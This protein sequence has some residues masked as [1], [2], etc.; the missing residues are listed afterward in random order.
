MPRK[1]KGTE[2]NQEQILE[3]QALFEGSDYGSVKIAEII[4]ERHKIAITEGSVRHYAKKGGWVKGKKKEYYNAKKLAKVEETLAKAKS[5]EKEYKLITKIS[6]QAEKEGERVA[7][8]TMQ[9]ETFKQQIEHQYAK[10]M[11]SLLQNFN[12]TQELTKSGKVTDTEFEYLGK[13]VDK[14][15]GKEVL[16]TV[17]RKTT[18]LRIKDYPD[19]VKIGQGLGFLQTPQQQQNTQINIGTQ[20][21]KDIINIDSQEIKQGIDKLHDNLVKSIETE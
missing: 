5:Q 10:A 16:G 15:S 11:M 2:L 17:I 6:K 1:A 9:N 4:S 8:L 14:E 7:L 12:T 13:V 18:T 20:Q 3:M 21:T 19:L